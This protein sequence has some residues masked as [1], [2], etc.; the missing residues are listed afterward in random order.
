MRCC[1]EGLDHV[2][3]R[4]LSELISDARRELAMRMAVRESP[5]GGK[6]G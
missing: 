3:V 4:V 1:L 2:Q 5:R 6:G